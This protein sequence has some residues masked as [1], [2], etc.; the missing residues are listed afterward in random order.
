MKGLGMLVV[1]LRA[2]SFGF[3]FHLGCSGQRVSF[4]VALEKYKNIYIVCVSTWSFLGVNKS[5][6]HA[7]IG[8]L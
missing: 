7:Q 6:G 4:R 8:L 2:V 3:W 1:S 5:L